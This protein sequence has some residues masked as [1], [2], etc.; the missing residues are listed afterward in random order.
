M[1][2]RC[3]PSGG[4]GILRRSELERRFRE[5]YPDVLPATIRKMGKREL[6]DRLGI[7]FRERAS[8]D[9]PMPVTDRKT[10]TNR[11]TRQFPNRYTREELVDLAKRVHPNYSKGILRRKKIGELCRLARLRYHHFETQARLQPVAPGEHQQ[12]QI[13]SRASS[14]RSSAADSGE[15]LPE[16]NCRTRGTKHLLAHQMDLMDR[17]DERRGIIAVHATGSGK[18]LSAVVASQC[19]LDQHPQSRVIVITPASLVDNF[20][21]ELDVFGPALRHRD[22]Y[23]IMSYQT[24]VNRKKNRRFRDDPTMD[25]RRT[26]LIVD[27]AHNFRTEYKKK[28]KRYQGIMTKHVLKCAEE[29]S[30]VL[31]LTATPIVNHLKDIVPLLNMIRDDARNPNTFITTP[32]FEANQFKV[33]FLRDHIQG[34]FHFFQPQDD[35]HREVYPATD[36]EIVFLTMNAEYLKKYMEIEELHA[37][38]DNLYIFGDVNLKTFFNGVRRATNTL[39]R[40]IRNP[41]QS[42]KIRWVLDFIMSLDPRRKMIV[43]SQFLDM[44]SLAVF[45]RLPPNIQEQ[46]GFITGNIP[47]KRRSDIVKAYNDGT[48]R[49]LFLSKAGGEGLDL[50]GTRDIVI[51][52]PSWN[53]SAEQQ[54]IGRGVRFMS[55]SHL[56]FD[57]RHVRIHRLIMIKPRDEEQLQD[58]LRFHSVTHPAGGYLSADLMMHN[59]QVHKQDTI[60]HY[61]GIIRANNT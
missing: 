60:D 10:C 4:R 33:P 16:Q 28:G 57:E 6:C 54:V 31:L 42:P 3:G 23:S 27:E 46:V 12:Q 5:R 1:E 37:T 56:P 21:R 19:Y 9:L 52:E 13:I 18:T 39:D 38:E 24:F 59:L 25:C 47:R 43:Y 17:F 29:A 45:R 15:D 55:H 2:P 51:L 14:G 53:M 35:V 34:K 40:S 61:L 58:I 41:T 7:P 30:K 26:L 44:G 11:R 48:L 8:D 20:A 50:K 32:H 49:I 36:T 22:R